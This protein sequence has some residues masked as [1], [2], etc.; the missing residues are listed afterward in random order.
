MTCGVPQGSV[1][2]PTLW[3]VFYDDLLSVKLPLGASLIGFADDLALVVVNHTTEGLKQAANESL[4][5]IEDWIN[6]NGL[7]LAHAKA[8]AIM[9]TR[10]WAYRQPLIVSGNLTVKVKWENSQAPRSLFTW[11]RS[12]LVTGRLG[13]TSTVS[14]CLTP[15][16]V[17]IAMR[18]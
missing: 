4:V 13:N 12:C 15:R 17:L 14:D 3:N 18:R 11:H 10:K 7:Q 5:K 1:L 9:L 8:E 6:S 16:S 2:G